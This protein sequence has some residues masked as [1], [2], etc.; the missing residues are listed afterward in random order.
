MS[1]SLQHDVMRKISRRTKDHFIVTYN[2]MSSLGPCET[3]STCDIVA[4]SFSFGVFLRDV[5]A[6]NV[7]F[8]QL[9]LVPN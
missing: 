6:T 4:G 2:V 9:K 5:F 7:R 8:R 1:I 3:F